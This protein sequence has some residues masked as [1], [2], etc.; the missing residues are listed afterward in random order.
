MAKK[1]S[2]KS[3]STSKHQSF[4]LSPHDYPRER[5]LVY[6]ICAFLVGFAIGWVLKDQYAAVLG[7]STY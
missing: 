5:V 4:K 7:I 3:K 2:T 1:K 6:A